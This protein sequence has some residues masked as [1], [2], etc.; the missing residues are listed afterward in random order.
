MAMALFEDKNAPVNIYRKGSAT[1]N[2]QGWMGK[3]PG[4]VADA[5]DTVAKL[6]P[7]VGG[8]G[9]AA[10]ATN[11]AGSAIVNRVVGDANAQA[12]TTGKP[13]ALT[14]RGGDMG[15]FRQIEAS[16]TAPQP[17]ANVA[18]FR[19][20]EAQNPAPKFGMVPGRPDRALDTETYG[21]QAK[22]VGGN[23]P[24]AV[25]AMATRGAAGA[26]GISV[27]L[28]PQDQQLKENMGKIDQLLAS[29]VQPNQPQAVAIDQLRRDAGFLRGGTDR[30]PVGPDGRPIGRGA[31]LNTGGRYSFQGTQDAAEKFVGA[32]SPGEY[33]PEAVAARGMQNKQ[34][35]THQGV[36]EVDPITGMTASQQKALPVK[37]RVALAGARLAAKT[38]TERTGVAKMQA[39]GTLELGR[40]NL[41]V[42]QA[43]QATKA[44]GAGLDMTAKQMEIDSRKNTEALIAKYDN[45]ETTPEEKARIEKSLINRGVLKQP[46]K[47]VEVVK[48]KLPAKLGEDGGEQVG[49]ANLVDGKIQWDGG[50]E[51]WEMREIQGNPAYLEAFNKADPKKQQEILAAMRAKRGM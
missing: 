24:Q 21:D 13:S 43:E 28:S 42:N 29:G 23:S 45:P 40:G 15:A 1:A 22:I 6:T 34:F 11:A 26:P 39:E 19:Q 51:G 44:K 38:E 48:R 8:A 14:M 2:A 18:A 32:V 30:V 17:S 3:A 27:N 37:E 20:A 36:E 46:A 33:S 35:L 25:A 12:V 4:A 50:G 49:V 31:G 5:V 41:A 9:L 47:Q 16:N 10:R 7:A